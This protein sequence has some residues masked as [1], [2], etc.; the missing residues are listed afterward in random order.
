MI[1]CNS[2]PRVADRSN[3][4]WRRALLIPWNI[5]ITKEKRVRGMDKVEWWQDSGELPGIFNW[6]LHGLIRL[7]EQKGFSYCQAMEDAMKDYRDEM[8][9]AGVFAKEHLELRQWAKIRSKNLYQMYSKWAKE[10]GYHPLSDKTFGKELKRIFKGIEK[11]RGGRQ[12]DRY[13]YYE[14]I[15]FT[16]DE[17]YGMRTCDAVVF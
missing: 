10:N 4:V 14:G 3:G 9:P 16:V 6:A 8:N 11:R 17:I 13:W 12:L 7:R 1:A 15:G 5:E 2:R